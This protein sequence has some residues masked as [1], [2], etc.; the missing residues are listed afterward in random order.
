MIVAV[1]CEGRHAFDSIRVPDIRLVQGLAE[2]ATAELVV[3]P[4]SQY[5]RYEH[6]ASTT[7]PETLVTRIREGRAGVILDS[8]LEGVPHKPDVTAALHG[9][10][11]R[12]RV[13]PARCVFLTQ[14][15]QYEASYRA[16]CT[17]AGLQPVGVLAHDYW[18][19]D[20]LDRFAENGEEA[21]AERLAAFRGRPSRRERTFVSLNR[22]PRPTK[23]LFLLRLLQDGLWS[24]GFI[25]FGGFR[26][27]PT[28]PGKPRPTPEQLTNAL[29]GFED[30]VA[31]LAPQ[32]D[33]L[34]G[35][36]RVLFGLERHGWRRLELGDSGLAG[37]FDEM[38]R[39]WFTAVTET[40][41]RPAP[42]R[43]T[44]KV[45]KP[46]VN[47][48]PM[49]LFGNP[50]ALSMIHDYGFATFDPLIDESYD[51][52]LDPR[53]RFDCAYAEF[54]RLC[55]MGDDELAAWES[56]LAERLIFNARW[57][58]TRF[59]TVF[60]GRCDSALVDRI[61]LRVLSR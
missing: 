35:Y 42:S 21:Y 22:T 8:S 28:G 53:R 47:F 23:I 9:L 4:C 12:W 39:S 43:I 58:L 40:E 1:G 25:S 7:L 45:L 38:D 2:S 18:M 37:H 33:A 46:L 48:H 32:I 52:E 41:M 16:H 59:P 60:R 24:R 19:W 44:E 20:A 13:P 3:F 14:D 10:L 54:V 55:R 34:A 50:G 15:R 26:T 36:G 57:G 5:R 30:L 17:A 29:P 11:E 56:A 27:G 61:R 49:V 31:H 6:L 51:R